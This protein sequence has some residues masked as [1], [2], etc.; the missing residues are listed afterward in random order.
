MKPIINKEQ[1]KWSNE[2]CQTVFDDTFMYFIADKKKMDQ[3]LNRTIK[4]YQKVLE[5]LPSDFL[6]RVTAAYL[7]GMSL[8][9][10]GWIHEYS[11]HAVF[12]NLTADQKRWLGIVKDN[13]W[14]YVLCFI[15]KD[16][17]NN[18]YTMF[19]PLTDEEF[20]LYSPGIAAYGKEYEHAMWFFLRTEKANCYQTYG[21][22]IPF[23]SITH[24][25]LFYLAIELNPTIETHEDFLKTV[26]TNPFPFYLSTIGSAYPITMN[27]SDQVV[28]CTSYFDIPDLDMETLKANF[29]VEWNQGVY[30]IS[31]PKWTE[32]PHF[33]NAYYVEKDEVL[34]CYAMTDRGFEAFINL[35]SIAGLPVN[36]FAD[37]RITPTMIVVLDKLGIKKVDRT[38]QFERLFTPKSDIGDEN[39]EKKIN[40]FMSLLVPYFNSGKEPNLEQLAKKSDIDLENAISLYQH[41]KESYSRMK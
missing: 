31:D 12:K 20:P 11:N 3:L 35:L 6:P 32:F 15:K 22:I 7:A 33:A 39:F 25:D 14:N 19:D 23:R 10:N 13:P 1:Q 9:P 37:E 26:R 17:G 18:Y 34:I 16:W 28:H 38:S 5:E 30:R 21:P 24:D 27:R 36:D 40:H 2:M 29:Q 8:G 41:L 4:K